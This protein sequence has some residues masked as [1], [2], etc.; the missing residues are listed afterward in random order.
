MLP[1]L[2]NNFLSSLGLVLQSIQPNLL[3]L[4]SLWQAIFFGQGW[5]WVACILESSPEYSLAPASAGRW[6]LTLLLLFSP[7]QPL[8]FQ[9]S[10][11]IASILQEV[12]LPSP[13]HSRARVFLGDY[14][15]NRFPPLRVSRTAITLHSGA[16]VLRAMTPISFSLLQTPR[17][18]LFL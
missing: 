1:S 5:K 2:K 6:S 18:R 15:L 14:L 4:T 9:V 10:T 8:L 12:F 16:Y 13:Q 7:G 3:N 11:T 17:T